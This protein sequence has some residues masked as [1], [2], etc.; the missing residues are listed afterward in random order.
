MEECFGATGFHPKDFEGGSAKDVPRAA[1]AIITVLVCL[2][3]MALVGWWARSC[4]VLPDRQYAVLSLSFEEAL[5][6]FGIFSEDPLERSNNG[7]VT[8]AWANHAVI[9]RSS[10]FVI[11][12]DHA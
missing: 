2:R 12:A 9:P 1:K 3:F 8:S 10:G 11:P 6:R 5:Q 7:G 4:L